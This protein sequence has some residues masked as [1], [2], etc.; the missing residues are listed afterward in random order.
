M[1]LRAWLL[2]M[3][4]LVAQG[5]FAQGREARQS[6]EYQAL[7]HVVRMYQVRTVN[8]GQLRDIPSLYVNGGPLIANDGGIVPYGATPAEDRGGY[9]IQISVYGPGAPPWDSLP[10]AN[11]IAAKSRRIDAPWGGRL[12]SLFVPFVPEPERAG[13]FS[14]GG[15]PASIRWSWEYPGYAVQIAH[16]WGGDTSEQEALRLI[17]PLAEALHRG[18]AEDGLGG[19]GEVAQSGGYHVRIH[20]GTLK[21]GDVLSPSVDVLDAQGRPAE[22][23]RGIAILIDGKFANSVTWDGR[24]AVIEAQVSVAGQGLVEQ[25][26]IPAW[27]T[28]PLPTATDEAPPALGPVGPLPPPRSLKETL[29]GVLAPP[30]LGLLGALASGLRGARAPRRPPPPTPK[31]KAKPGPKTPSEAR[32]PALTRAERTLDHLAQVAQTTGDKELAQAVANART[33]AIG[34]DGKLDPAAWKEAQQTLREALGKL[35]QGIPQPTSVLGDTARAAGTAVKELGL[36]IGKGPYGI[37][38]GIFNLGA[39]AWTGLKGIAH[40][41]MNPRDFERGV[42]EILKNFGREHLAAENKAFGE[43]LREGRYGDALKAL[44][45][46]MLKTA[47]HALGGAWEWVRREILPWDEFKSFFD[48]HASAEE[49]LWAIPAAAMKIA[50]IATLF[51][52]PTTVPST[53]WGTALENAL[54]GRAASGLAQVSAEATRKVGQLEQQLGALQKAGGTAPNSTVQQM[55]GRTQKALEQA[56]VAQQAAQKAHEVERLARQAMRGREAFAN[57]Q[58]AQHAL[59]QNPQ[60][61]AAIDDAIRA[62]QGGNALYELRARGLISQD[63]HALMTARKLQL[64]DQAVNAASKRVIEQ[65]V[66]ALQAAGQ[67]IPRRFDTFNATQGSRSRLSGSNIQADL[68]QT[69]LGLKNVSREEAERVI[70]EECRRLGMTQQQLDINIYR[71]GKGLMDARGAAPNAQVTLENIGQTTGTAGHH[72]VHVDRKGQVHVG[73]HVS[74]PQGR[75][76]V[77]AGRRTMDPPPGMSRQQW[78]REGVWEGHQGAPVQIPREQW[79]AVRQTQLEGIHHAFERGDMNQMVKYANRARGVGFAMDEPTARVVR[80]VAGQKD[81]AIAARMLREAGIRNPAELLQR[82]G[83]QH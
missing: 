72:P 64:Q 6:D 59:A 79:P 56:R 50:S 24:R 13:P 65:E 73:N 14:E 45:Q 33:Q 44:A 54:D 38:A 29:V 17:R 5:V 40:G 49:R 76:G 7:R 80:A 30:L 3:L 15:N 37:G 58:Q 26:V 63:A 42:R 25:L 34:K 55:L 75:E 78:L 74:T 21:P 10:G 36:G 31:P 66:K 43:G 2:T 52:K 48:P 22:D 39:N 9:S 41:L 82:L 18:F 46:G 27:G 32:D 83:L 23:V 12:Y 28:A 35:E 47:G 61:T 68:D 67:P 81:P 71:P 4:L 77:L 60:L 16:F 51:T 62:N 70:R 19:E 57:F 53:R 8:S 20:V 11:Y 69:V 1:S